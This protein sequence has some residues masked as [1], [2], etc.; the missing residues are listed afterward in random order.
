MI[1]VI[2][3]RAFNVLMKKP[4]RL[5]GISLLSTLLIPL[6]SGL[7]GFA[8][9][10]LGIAVTQLISTSMTMVYLHGYRGEQV[11]VVH[12]FDCFQDWATIKRVLCGTAWALLW[13]VLWSLVPFVGFI[14][15]II[16][17]YEYRLV[18]YILVTEPDVA[19]TE[20]IKVS[21]KRT[22]GYK[23]KMF[24]AELLT[25]VIIFGV[26]LVLGILCAIPYIGVLFALVM[27][28]AYVATFALTPLFLGLVGAAF[29]EEISHPSVPLQPVA[30][31]APV[32]QQPQA[33]RY[34]QPTYPPQQPV[35]QQPQAPQSSL[36]PQQK[37]ASAFC[38]N[39]GAA[40]NPGTAFCSNCG[41]RV[42]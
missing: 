39:C 12:L 23:M 15:A 32:Y 29:Y 16:R 11:K 9:P 8:I 22:Q 42:R 27:L 33:P 18:P 10:I 34:Q 25:F 24:L 26:F 21:A 4:L 14:F 19:P 37:P 2:F 7:C 13:Q 31:V 28:V 35:Y 5:W 40:L 30:P 17:S 3:S 6:L 1:K 36:A 41:S 38:P 20:A